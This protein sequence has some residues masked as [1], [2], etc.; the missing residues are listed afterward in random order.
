[1]LINSAGDLLWAGGISPFAEHHGN[2]SA[3]TFSSFCILLILCYIRL[4]SESWGQLWEVIIWLI[5]FNANSILY[6][7]SDSK[8]DCVMIQN[9]VSEHCAILE[10]YMEQN[11][12]WKGINPDKW[13]LEGIWD[14]CAIVHAAGLFP[15]WGSATGFLS[16]FVLRNRVQLPSSHDNSKTNT[17]DWLCYNKHHNKRHFTLAVA[18]EQT[19]WKKWESYGLENKPMNWESG[20]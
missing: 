9:L 18:P 5:C 20:D 13:W 10:G 1:M 14:H 16:L 17:W 4:K 15:L 6:I 19:F 8:A 2:A 3:F 7:P 11:N 12:L